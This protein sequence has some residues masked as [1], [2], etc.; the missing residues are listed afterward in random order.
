MNKRNELIKNLKPS[1][2]A[3]LYQLDLIIQN[4]QQPVHVTTLMNLT[5]YER[6]TVQRAIKAA[7]SL[8]LYQ[9]KRNKPNDPYTYTQSI[10][11][12]PLNN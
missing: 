9:R 10:P 3:V 4:N 11:P 2:Q 6:R 8:N 12:S 5:G 7:I 1:Y